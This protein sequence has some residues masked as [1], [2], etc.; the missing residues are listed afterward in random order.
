MPS[1]YSTLVVLRGL[2][3]ITLLLGI[4]GTGIELLLLDHTEGF[5]QLAPLALLGVALLVLT[6]HLIA[7]SPGSVRVVQLLMLAFILSGFAGLFLHYSGNVEFERELHTAAAGFELFREALKGATPTL[8]PG[9][10]IQLGLVGLVYT[11]RHP[12]LAARGTAGSAPITRE[13]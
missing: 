1:R 11:Y 13:Q 9:T 2:L 5:W 12:A 10:M 3:L 8:A 7:R 6:W 4:A